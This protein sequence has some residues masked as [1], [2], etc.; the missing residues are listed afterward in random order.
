[1]IQTTMKSN[2]T[3]FFDSLGK[4]A[5]DFPRIAFE[6]GQTAFKKTREPLL[7][8]LRI[9]PPKLPNQK[10]IRT[11]KL[12]RGWKVFI[13]RINPKSFAIV[14]SNNVDYTSFVVGSLAIAE[15]VADSFQADIH[16]GR[17]KLA[18]ITVQEQFHEF[19]I[20][21][22]KQLEKQLGQFGTISRTRL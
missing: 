22:D 13:Q 12:R 14:V 21:Y 1:M 9:Y 5:E 3:P 10:Y 18:T 2:F 17:W 19:L 20:E 4:F 6:T 7:D 11:F 8:E 16:R 15:S